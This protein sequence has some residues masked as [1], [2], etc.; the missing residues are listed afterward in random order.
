[1]GADSYEITSQVFQSFFA[2]LT[3]VSTPPIIVDSCKSIKESE[4]RHLYDFKRTRSSLLKD[5][6]VT[7]F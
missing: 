3:K 4:N 1:M 7:I 2:D 5:L 6:S